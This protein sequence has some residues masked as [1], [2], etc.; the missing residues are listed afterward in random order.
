M[1]APCTPCPYS[2]PRSVGGA[3]NG[4]NASIHPGD[5]GGS[6]LSF[7]IKA[8]KFLLSH[9]LY[10]WVFFDQTLHLGHILLGSNGHKL[11]TTATVFK[12]RSDELKFLV[13]LVNCRSRWRMVPKAV[14]QTLQALLERLPL[15]AIVIHHCTKIFL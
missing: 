15:T 7:P 2:V 9:F 11:A 4:R 12:R 6:D 13:P 1:K 10:S 3:P 8:K 14:L 5:D